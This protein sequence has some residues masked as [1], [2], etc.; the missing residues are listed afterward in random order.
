MILTHRRSVLYSSSKY[1]IFLFKHRNAFAT[2]LVSKDRVLGHNPAGALCTGGAYPRHVRGHQ[3]V[4]KNFS[5]PLRDQAL[6]SGVR[7]LE[8]VFVMGG[9][10]GRHAAEAAVE[11]GRPHIPWAE[12]ADEE[13]RLKARFSEKGSRSRSEA[14][15]MLLP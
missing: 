1:L 15:K 3:N 12:I 6:R 13:D 7:F 8:K 11:L 9:M 4:G 5:L 2:M 14:T 10:A